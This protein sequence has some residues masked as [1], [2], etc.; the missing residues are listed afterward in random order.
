MAAVQSLHGTTP[1]RHVRWTEGVGLLATALP[2]EAYH[3]A[4]VFHNFNFT[5]GYG[6]YAEDVPTFVPARDDM[7]LDTI[8]R[9]IRQRVA[10]WCDTPL[11]APSAP[12][13]GSRRRRGRGQ[14][15]RLAPAV[16]TATE[17][18][19]MRRAEAYFRASATVGIRVFTC[20]SRTICT[21]RDDETLHVEV[22]GTSRAGESL[23]LTVNEVPL[24][25]EQR[26]AMALA[27]VC[28]LV[29]GGTKDI[30]TISD[31][32]LDV[33]RR[34]TLTPVRWL[35]QGAMQIRTMDSDL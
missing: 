5:S 22:K 7:V 3:Q 14:G 29:V 32:T 15:S 31:G 33:S 9:L 6:C 16:R 20:A 1:G 10:A 8:T 34:E 30:P 19:A 35:P 18:E 28:D 21:V 4:Y 2:L 27:V 25:R 26:D 13:I 12:A 11:T 24:A 17:T 23:R